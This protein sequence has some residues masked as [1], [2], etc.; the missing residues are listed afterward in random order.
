MLK[1][2]Q[3][4]QLSLR[5]PTPDTPPG[6]SKSFFLYMWMCLNTAKK[7]NTGFPHPCVNIFETHPDLT[8]LQNLARIVPKM[9]GYANPVVGILVFQPFWI[10]DLYD[11]REPEGDYKV[12]L[13]SLLN[14]LFVMFP[15]P[16]PLYDYWED[17]ELEPFSKWVM[18]FILLGQGGSLFRVAEFFE[19]NIPKKLVRYIHEMPRGLTPREGAM[20]AY[21]QYLGRDG[22]GIS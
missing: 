12:K 6:N 21:I 3:F 7:S 11:W 14:H 4:P 16:E 18:W 20:Y 17:K 15:V 10:R 19:W 2:S 1:L 13:R 9:P 8:I 5:S 22:S